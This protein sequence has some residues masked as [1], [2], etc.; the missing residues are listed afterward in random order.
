METEAA[1]AMEEAVEA[2]SGLR[3]HIAVAMGRRSGPI[4]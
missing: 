4:I 1:E 3:G 2:Q